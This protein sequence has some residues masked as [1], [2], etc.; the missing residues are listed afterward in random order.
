M[1]F[2][3]SVLFASFLLSST[4]D[5]AKQYFDQKSYDRA[6]SL[7]QSTIDAKSANAKTYALASK[8]ASKLDELDDAN[9][10]II[11]AIEDDPSNKEY[12]EFQKQLELL[13]NAL[14]DAKKTFDSGYHEEA[15]AD[16]NKLSET[17][18][19]NAMIRYTKGLVLKKIGNLDEA[20]ENYKKAVELNPFEDKYR[21]AILVVAQTLAKKG[22]EEF[23]RKE[24]TTA[25]DFYNKS[26]SYYP[27]FVD[28]AF[29]LAKTYFVMKDFTNAQK[30]S[31]NVIEIDDSH[32][33]AIKMLGDIYKRDG[34][35]NK[36]IELYSR[37]IEINSN[38]DRAYYSLGVAYK[39]NQQYDFAIDALSKALLVS[40]TYTKAYETLGVVYEQKND[41]DN[42]LYSIAIVPILVA[43]VGIFVGWLR[44]EL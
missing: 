14:K 1:K 24:Y 31:K 20:I 17:Y 9:S 40:P 38:Y 15:I 34:D 10:F 11:K 25:L 4:Y 26:V 22:D 37:A 44:K 36:A 6:K 39:D 3:F 5:E 27:K 21:K 43:F 19:E 35:R 42:L 29:R 32:V 28:G 23:R 18:P 12:R 2:I 7:L 30:W 13:K 41:F 33:Q 8:V 16:Y